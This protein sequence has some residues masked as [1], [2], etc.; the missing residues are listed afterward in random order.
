MG[1]S[2][3]QDFAR[4]TDPERLEGE[5]MLLFTGPLK[6]RN[7][8]SIYPGIPSLHSRVH[9]ATLN[10]V[11]TLYDARLALRLHAQSAGGSSTDPHSRPLEIGLVEDALYLPLARAFKQ[12]VARFA[13]HI[14]SPNLGI[15]IL[16]NKL[17]ITPVRSLKLAISASARGWAADSS[18]GNGVT[19]VNWRGVL[20]IDATENLLRALG[21][22]RCMRRREFG[23]ES[24]IHGVGVRAPALLTFDAEPWGIDG[25]MGRTCV[26]DSA[27]GCAV[28][29][30]TESDAEPWDLRGGCACVGAADFDAEPWGW[31]G[32]NL[33]RIRGI[34]G[35]PESGAGLWGFGLRLPALLTWRGAFGIHGWMARNNSIARTARSGCAQ[36]ETKD[37]ERTPWGSEGYKGACQPALIHTDCFR[38][39]FSRTTAARECPLGEGTRPEDAVAGRAAPDVSHGCPP[40]AACRAR[41]RPSNRLSA[42][43]D[44]VGMLCEAASRVGCFHRSLAWRKTRKWLEGGI[45]AGSDLEKMAR[46]IHVREHLVLVSLL[47]PA[48]PAA[49]GSNSAAAFPLPPAARL[50]PLMTRLLTLTYVHGVQVWDASALGTVLEDR[51]SV[52]GVVDLFM[53][54]ASLCICAAEGVVVEIDVCV[55]AVADVY[56]DDSWR[57]VYDADVRRP[58]LRPFY[59]TGVLHSLNTRV[60]LAETTPHALYVYSLALGRV[61]AVWAPPTS[62]SV[63]SNDAHR[64]RDRDREQERDKHTIGRPNAF[65]VSG[66]ILIVSLQHCYELLRRCYAAATTCYAAATRLL[67]ECYKLLRLSTGSYGLL[68]SATNSYANPTSCYKLLRRSYAAL[69]T[70]TP[71][72]DLYAAP[73]SHYPVSTRFYWV[74]WELYELLRA[75]TP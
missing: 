61:V 2:R 75:S 68:H 67:R 11:L 64:A 50:L 12:R 44:N 71:L 33:A 21:F 48:E 38:L 47:V 26:C 19:T 16:R 20:G 39:H 35:V 7:Y 46:T 34:H 66:K 63:S 55:F 23:A 45:K 62:S 31:D 4:I 57:R 29:F 9:S 42:N 32:G 28:L 14:F 43:D 13:P 8:G 69:P 24:G 6:R 30:F 49:P 40:L 41:L 70:A 51:G 60:L 3:L 72:Y 53:R 54:C 22:T 37:S 15:R 59:E 25:R 17:C 52:V 27:Q 1:T 18:A 74:L 73:T 10:G 5:T 36:G 65:N 58:R 56:G